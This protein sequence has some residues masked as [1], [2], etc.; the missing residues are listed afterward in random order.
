MVFDVG[1]LI[2]FG[3]LCPD[4]PA[5]ARWAMAGLWGRDTI[6]WACVVGY[7]LGGDPEFVM[8]IRAVGER[9]VELCNQGKNFD[10]MHTMY[11]EDIVSVEPTGKAT[12]G[13][14]AVI[15]KSEVWAGGGDDP[16]GDGGGAFLPRG[17]QV[18]DDD[19]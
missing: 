5:K 19:V 18:R 6:G 2:L 12:A 14:G 15:K 16:R 13:K 11:A 9:L 4:T 10:V 8:D 3:A 17:G 1:D 7:F